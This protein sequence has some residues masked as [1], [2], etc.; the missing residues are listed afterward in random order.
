MK[1]QM[2]SAL[3]CIYLVRYVY[4]DITQHNFCKSV[5]KVFLVDLE[6]LVVGSTA[7]MK[8]ELAIVKCTL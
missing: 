6:M 3:T 1:I 5:K 4:G 8:A 2:K 7:K